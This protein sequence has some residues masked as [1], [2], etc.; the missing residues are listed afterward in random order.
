MPTTDPRY[1]LGLFKTPDAYTD[2][3]RAA[4][5][6]TIAETPKKLRTAVKGL[7]DRQLDTPYRE[8]GWTVRQLVH[9]VPD[10]HVN[11]Y[12]RTRLALTE[13]NPTIKPYDQQKWAE[14]ADAKSFPIEPSLTMLDA[15]H[16][17]WVALLGSMKPADFSRAFVHPEHGPRTLDWMVAIYAW[18]GPHHVAHVT[19]LRKRNGW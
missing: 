7:S 2:A 11:A 17:R 15:I 13:D 8:G 18:H 19:E 12:V 9:H 16:E 3:S 1:P 4:A 14:L 5:I 10:S 6:A